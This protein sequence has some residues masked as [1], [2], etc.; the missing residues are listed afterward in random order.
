M[1]PS[2]LED[3]FARADQKLCGGY[4]VLSLLC[5]LQTLYLELAAPGLVQQVGPEKRRQVVDVHS[6]AWQLQANKTM[7]AN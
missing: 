7:R 3:L 1:I 4:D 6:V 2:Y 5:S